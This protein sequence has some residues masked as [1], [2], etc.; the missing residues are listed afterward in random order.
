MEKVTPEALSIATASV[1]F[2]LLSALQRKGVLTAK[3]I[4]ALMMDVYLSHMTPEGDYPSEANK[5]AQ[6]FLTEAWASLQD[7]RDQPPP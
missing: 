1:L 4:D 6:A 2:Q 3:E 7:D 5:K